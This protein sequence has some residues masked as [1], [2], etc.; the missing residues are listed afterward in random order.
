MTVRVVHYLNQYFAGI[1]GEDKADAP[2]AFKSGPLGPGVALQDALGEG[3]EVVGTVF[4][5]DSYM[6]EN[7]DSGSARTVSLIAELSP[8]VLVAGPAFAS[9]R[10]GLA[11]G[12]VCVAAERDL[13]IRTLTAFHEENPATEQFRE[14]VVILPTR[15]SAV[16][17][18]DAVSSLSRLAMKL[19]RGEVLGGPEEEGYFNRGFRRNVFT[20]RTGAERVVDMVLAKLSGRDFATEWPLPKYDRVSPPAPLQATNPRLALVSEGGVVPKGNPDRIPSAWATNWGT[21]ELGGVEDLTSEAFETVHGGFD[22]TIANEDP[23]RLIP[24]D[25]ARSLEDAGELVL[26]QK[27]YSTTGNMGSITQM[28]RIGSE[29]AK[30][31][32][33][34]GV[35]AVIVGAT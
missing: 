21:Y 26:V 9:G 5:G 2:P 8:D 14:R 32:S 15:E 18:R 3:G 23:D 29:M 35:E 1:G 19:G 28:A 7:L 12:H 4:A 24:L 34:S 27:L 20:D 22:T 17:M 10:Y 33:S 11:C 13:K 25:A 31:L 6:A 30:K 16:G